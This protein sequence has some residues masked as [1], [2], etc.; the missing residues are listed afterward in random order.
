MDPQHQ[1]K[2]GDG[3]KAVARLSGVSLAALAR[4]SSIPYPRLLRL[5]NGQRRFRPGELS[6]IAGL[7]GLSLP[8]LILPKGRK[9]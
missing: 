9:P 5:L 4:R 6:R 3:L 1:Y 2:I 8:H 7:L